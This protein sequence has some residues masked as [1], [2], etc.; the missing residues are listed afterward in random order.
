[1]DVEQLADLY[2]RDELTEE[3]KSEL[4]TL[5]ENDEEQSRLFTE[6]LYETGQLLNAVDQLAEVSPQLDA[7]GDLMAE[8]KLK[9]N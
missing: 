8:Q 1:M 3:Q 2:L 5:L 9:R 7:L 6:Y 4:K